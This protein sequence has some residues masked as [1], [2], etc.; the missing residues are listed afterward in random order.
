MKHIY[1]CGFMGCGKTTVG[2][3]AAVLAGAQFIDLDDAIIEA[4]G[5]PIPEIFKEDG[6]DAF[7]R[8]EAD[9]LRATAES[10]TPL[11]VAT[12]GGAL[13]FP[14]N[15]AF[16][17]ENGVTVFLDVPFDLCYERIR[18]DKNRPVAAGRSEEELRALF[19]VRRKLYLEAAAVIL[20]NASLNEQAEKIAKLFG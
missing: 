9:V 15:A 10:E 19:A 16:C 3:A 4:A 11:I 18:T 13:T 17:K 6:E 12:G 14:Q 20:P 5:K 8:I 2:K 7:R 1:L